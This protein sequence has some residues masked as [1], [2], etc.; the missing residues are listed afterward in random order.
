MQNKKL[1]R[2]FANPFT[3]VIC[4]CSILIDGA[5][6]AAPY[7]WYIRYAAADGQPFALVGIVAIAVALMSLFPRIR[8]LQ[9]ISLLLMWVSLI[10]FYLQ[11]NPASRASIFGLPITFIMLAVFAIVS[12]LVVLKS[13]SWKNS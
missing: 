6:F 9:L 13:F 11:T 1:Y 10:M 12:V 2:L 4:F 8:K 7:G 3:L 5:V